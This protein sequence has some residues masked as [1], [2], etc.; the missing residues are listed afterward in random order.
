MEQRVVV[1]PAGNTLR[2][3]LGGA[4]IAESHRAKVVHEKGLPPRYY[5]PREDVSAGALEGTGA[6]VCPWKGKWRHV[7]IEAAGQRVQNAAWTYFETTEACETIRDHLAF[8]P[9]RVDAIEID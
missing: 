3:R 5:F 4:V 9:E 2:V 6:G 8:Y 1:Q 7:D